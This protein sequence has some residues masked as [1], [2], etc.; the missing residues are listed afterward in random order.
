MQIIDRIEIVE[1]ASI[2]GFSQKSQTMLKIYIYK[3]E[4]IKS[5]GSMLNSGAIFGYCFQP[6]ETHLS[7]FTKCYCD[8]NL[9]GMDI[10]NLT[11]FSFRL[12]LPKANT[13]GNFY[14]TYFPS[15]F[16][17]SET[18]D[19]NPIYE[20]LQECKYKF[21]QYSI[22]FMYLERSIIVCK[23]RFSKSLYKFLPV[24]FYT[25]YTK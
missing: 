24:I 7:Y 3:P 17:S 12:P 6:Y 13:F 11:K 9:F 25:T 18:N 22:K 16:I 1:K 14:K 5:L 19:L 20:S 23:F 8:C 21:I 10:V 15:E 2:Y 4:L